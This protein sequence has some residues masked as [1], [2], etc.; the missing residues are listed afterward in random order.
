[1]FRACCDKLFK[2]EYLDLNNIYLKYN[3]SLLVCFRLDL[4][5]RP[6]SFQPCALPTELLKPILSCHSLRFYLF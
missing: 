5:Q 1:M 6:Q 3:L 2:N 4:N